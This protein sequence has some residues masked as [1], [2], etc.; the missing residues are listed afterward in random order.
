MP[1]ILDKC[2]AELQK[3]GK[4][5]SSAYAICTASLKKSGDLNDDEL[6]RLSNLSEDSDEYR[7]LMKDYNDWLKD[8]ESILSADIS[9]VRKFSFPV[10]FP[11]EKD[12]AS[13]KTST[14]QILKQG[15]FMHPW[16]GR[17]IFDEAFFDKMIANFNANIPQEQ[18]A[19]DFNHFPDW[20]ASAWVKKLFKE[21]NALMAEVEWT[22]KGKESVSNKEFIYFSSSYTD[23]YKEF[24]FLEKQDD[25]GNSY[26]EEVSVNHGPT[27]LG[28]GLTNRPFLKGMKPVSLSENGDQTIILEEVI[29]DNIENK[30]RGNLNKNFEEVTNK[31]AK[32]I[33]ELKVEQKNLSDQIEDLK[34]KDDDESKAKV[35]ELSDKVKG[36]ND[37]ITSMEKTT[38]DKEKEL[39]ETKTA[40]EAEKE[41]TKELEKKLSDQKAANDD[42][43]SKIKDLSDS[44]TKLLNERKETNIR[45]YNESVKSTI[46]DLK[47]AGAFPSMI[48]VMEPVLLSDQGRSVTI[49]L[50]EGEGENKKDITKDL[51]TI[52]KEIVQAIPEENRFSDKEESESVTTLNGAT[53][54]ELSEDDVQKYADEHKLSYEDALIALDKE[55]K[56]V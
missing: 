49:N 31:M 11:E 32:T 8:Q 23:N 29:E 7:E 25:E 55:G 41:K 10:T 54:K 3:K 14:V 1:E 24:Y 52:F 47:D 22:K 30:A 36:L 46:R 34:G 19:F 48:A 53:G 4:S 9:P 21:D 27:L 45:V 50:S 5:K 20:G 44:V 35:K 38:E 51:S 17:I 16:Y 26:D 12:L 42:N 13:K 28:G 2:V 56:L 33:E 43:A 37:Q 18:I 39:S 40:L 15:K 6:N